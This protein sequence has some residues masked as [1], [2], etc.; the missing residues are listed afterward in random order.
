MWQKGYETGRNMRTASPRLKSLEDVSGSSLIETCDES[1]QLVQA[2]R[3]KSIALP[4]EGYLGG[5]EHELYGL[6][7]FRLVSS[8][9]LPHRLFPACNRHGYF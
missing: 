1:G 5:H 9:L 3:R 7:P 4:Q 2:K 6:P 8:L